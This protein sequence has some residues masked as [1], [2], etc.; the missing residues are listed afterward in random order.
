MVVSPER[1]L[2]LQK[3]RSVWSNNCMK[4]RELKEHIPK[5]PVGRPRI[6]P[7]KID[8]VDKFINQNADRFVFNDEDILTDINEDITEINEDT[9]NIDED[10]NEDIDEIVEVVEVPKKKKIIKK[11]IKYIEEDDDDNDDELL[12]YT[13][14]FANYNQN[15]YQMP[16][17]VYEA[18]TP[19]QMIYNEVPINTNKQQIN[20]FNY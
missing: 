9:T 18:I 16:P 11:I 10:T 19:K 2:I 3:A 12:Q 1:L 13:N 4:I 20:F 6:R 8:L 15:Q 7:E 14:K 17:N 5:R